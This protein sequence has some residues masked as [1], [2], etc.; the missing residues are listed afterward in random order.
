[1]GAASSSGQ[2]RQQ[3]AHGLDARSGPAR[4]P[5]PPARSAAARP[6]FTSVTTVWR[7]TSSTRSWAERLAQL[8]LAGAR[9]AA[10]G[11]SPDPLSAAI[12]ALR[13]GHLGAVDLL[14]RGPAR[15][16]PPLAL[17]AALAAAGPPPCPSAAR[18]G[19]VQA[20]RR[21]PIAAAGYSSCAVEVDQLAVQPVADRAPEV[22][23][24]QAAG[25]RLVRARPRRTRGPPAPRRPRSGRPARWTPRPWSAHRRCAPPPCRTR[26]GAGRST[27]AGCARRSS[28]CARG[29]PRSPRRR[30]KLPNGSGMPQ[31]GK[32]LVKIWVRAEWRPESRPSR[33]GEFDESASSSGSSAPKAVAHGHRAVGAADAHVHV[34]AEG[35]VAP[36]H[37]LEVVLDAA[38]VLGVDDPLLLPRAPGVGARGAQ[39]RVR[40]RRP[41]RNSRARASRWRASASARS[42]PRP[43]RI[44]ISDWISSPA[45]DSREHARRLPRRP[46]LLEALGQR[47]RGG[48]E[49]REL[50]LDA[51]RE[52]GGGVE[53]LPAWS[54]CPA[55][56]GYP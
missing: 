16:R 23:L 12:G 19:A 36:G 21:S 13:G 32:L 40:G 17:G 27:R 43:E 42:S 52:V 47:V 18:A 54:P 53:R 37:V 45:T 30:A 35:V 11:R 38:V 1:M 50:L 7:T 49:D 6:R 26:D 9:R 56:R 14:D 44:S 5:S 8:L 10:A 39:Q 48:I 20:M 55:R 46:Q 31:R 33:N 41:A 24:D 25:G 29:S 28:S 34:G 22:L 2:Q 51:H 15:E 4:G 3:G